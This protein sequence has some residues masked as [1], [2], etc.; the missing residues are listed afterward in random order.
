M[1]LGVPGRVEE[2]SGEDPIF[3]TATVSFGGT[4]REVSLA[5]VPRA[6]EGDW[7]IVHAGFA[8]SILREEEAMEVFE[9]LRQISEMGAEEL[10]TESSILSGN[11]IP[12]AGT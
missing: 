9:Y 10:P 7:V 8:L 12:D 1:C 3:R 2:I 6:E 11:N 4:L 5:G